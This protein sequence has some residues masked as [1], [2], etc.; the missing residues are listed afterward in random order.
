MCC[1]SSLGAAGE[2]AEGATGGAKSGSSERRDLSVTDSKNRA[3]PGAAKCFKM[4]IIEEAAWTCLGLLWMSWLYFCFLQSPAGETLQLPLRKN[5]SETS[6]AA[7][8]PARQSRRAGNHI[9]LLL[10]SQKL[11]QFARRRYET[12][13]S[14][15]IGSL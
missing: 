6:S 13:K 2:G 15:E 8:F 9:A 12:V 4:R 1:L 10:Y 11:D 7:S 3:I 5:F 14:E